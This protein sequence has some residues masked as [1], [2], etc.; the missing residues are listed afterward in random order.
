MEPR[1]GRVREMISTGCTLA[2]LLDFLRSCDS[3]KLTPLNF[4]RILNESYGIPMLESREIV[5]MCGPD[6]RPIVTT[7]EFELRWRQTVEAHA[8]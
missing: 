8:S 2:E 1:S 7:D 5:A 3:Y 4:M 6:L